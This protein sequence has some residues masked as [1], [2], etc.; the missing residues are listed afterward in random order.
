MYVLFLI[1]KRTIIN[2]N[3]EAIINAGKEVDPEIK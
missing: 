2:K 3:T 1:L